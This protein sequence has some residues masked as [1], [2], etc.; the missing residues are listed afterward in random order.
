MNSTSA[1]TAPNFIHMRRVATVLLVFMAL[2]S[3]ACLLFV[4]EFPWLEIVAAFSEAAMVGALADW[5]AVTALLRQPLGLPI[6]HTAIIPNNKGRIGRNLGQFIEQHFISED[7]LSK[8]NFD[9]AGPLARWLSHIENR[10]F[11]LARIRRVARRLVEALEDEEIGLLL[12]QGVV[13]ELGRIDASS[14]VAS[15]LELLT[16][17]ETHELVLDELLKLSR[18]FFSTNQPWIRDKIREAC[19]WF[20]PAFVDRKIFEVVVEKIEQTFRDALVDRAHELRVRIHQAGGGLVERLRTD[21]DFRETCNELK[22]AILSNPDFLSYVNSM[23][24]G[25]SR[26]ILES[27]EN[28]EPRLMD[29]IHRVL[30]RFSDIVVDDDSVRERVN[31][32]LRSLVGMLLGNHRHDIGVTIART[33]ESWDFATIVERFE[34]QVGKDLQYIRINGTI[35]GGLVGLILYFI[36]SILI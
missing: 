22:K 30:V 33:V 27:L 24:E 6:P 8:H 18:E 32:T 4:E 15:T 9:L 19:P 13:A 7:I 5:F 28:E 26:I 20:V 35:V 11:V 12:K 31:S 21:N 34:A 23:R 14:A 29:P 3:F 2:L 17:D 1:I 16:R 25:I 36:K 10:V